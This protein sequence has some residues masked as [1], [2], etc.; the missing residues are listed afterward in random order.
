MGTIASIGVDAK[1]HRMLALSNDWAATDYQVPADAKFISISGREKLL[2]LHTSDYENLQKMYCGIYRTN[3]IKV[4]R[5]VKYL[6]QVI[7]RGECFRSHKTDTINCNVVQA[8]W[9]SQNR[10]F[11][12][13][14]A[15]PLTRSGVVTGIIFSNVDVGG[16]IKQHLILHIN[17]YEVH[18]NMYAYGHHVRMYHKQFCDSGDYSFMPIQRVVSKCAITNVKYQNITAGVI[19]PLHGQWAIC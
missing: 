4:A 15:E 3:D 12:I 11:R 5:R 2:Y 10:P 17:W 7:Y 6:N 1:V 16:Q 9:L 13:N 18:E 19:I 14:T 8:K